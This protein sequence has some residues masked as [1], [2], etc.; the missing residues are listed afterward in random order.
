M[1]HNSLELR[2]VWLLQLNIPT[3]LGLKDPVPNNGQQASA[4]HALTY[5]PFAG[6][7]HPG[8]IRHL[9]YKDSHGVGV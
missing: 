9:K 8:A 5:P 2:E 7:L 6:R 4:D 3:E 1:Q